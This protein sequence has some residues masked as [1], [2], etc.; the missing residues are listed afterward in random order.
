MDEAFITLNIVNRSFNELLLPLEY[1]QGAPIGFLFIEKLLVN[2]LGNS[3]YVLRLYPFLCGILSIFIFYK[4]T[5][6]LISSKSVL[7][8]VLL[9]SISPFLIYY[10]SEVKQFS[11]DVFFT[12]LLYALFIYVESDRLTIWRLLLFGIIGASAIWFSHAAVFILAGIGLS[13]FLSYLVRKDWVLS[14]RLSIVFLMWILSFS[15]L[16]FLSLNELGKN[17]DLLNSWAKNFPPF[18][19]IRIYQFKWYIDKFFEVFRNPVGLRPSGIAAFLCI[20]GSISIFNKKRIAFLSLILPTAFLLLASILHKY[21]LSGRLLLFMVPV[22]IILIAEGAEYIRVEFDERH[23]VIWL[24][25]MAILFFYPIYDAYKDFKKPLRREEIKLVMEYA[26]QRWQPGDILYVYYGA[27]PAFKYYSEKYGFGESSYI[28]GVKSRDDWNKYREELNRLDG[29]NRVWI[30]FSHVYKWGSVDEEK[31]FLH[32]L[33][34]HGTRLDY[35]KGYNA[36]VYLYT[37]DNLKN[38]LQLTQE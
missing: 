14:I 23:S 17:S 19:P 20:I 3:E 34:S 33:E 26:K 21:P 16:Y 2:S 29:K 4:I 8:A 15:V 10:S 30:L 1:N 18:P 7:I 32:F 9:F 36:T 12:L 6:S 28:L 38:I 22:L 37:F 5:K 24:T 13:L 35:F 31:L 11:S 25:C 27:H